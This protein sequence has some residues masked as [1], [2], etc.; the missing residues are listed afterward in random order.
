MR[1]TFSN[2]MIGLKDPMKQRDA[3]EIDFDQSGC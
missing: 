3:T 2:C 1:V